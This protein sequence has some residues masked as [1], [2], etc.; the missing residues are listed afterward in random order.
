MS[1][2]FVL[3]SCYSFHVLAD[4]EIDDLRPRLDNEWVQIQEDK[5]NDIRAYIRHED[6]KPFRSFKADMRLDVSIKTL[7]SVILNFDNYTKWYWKTQTS[8]ILKEHSP[9]HFIIYVVHDAPYNI[10][11]L[12]VILDAVVKPQS[13]SQASI[14]LKVSALPDY[15]AVKPHLKRMLAEDMSVKITPLPNDRVHV[16][17]HGYFEVRNHILP[18]WAANI[19]QRTAPYTVLT[20]LKKIAHLTHHQKSST[21][22]GFAV[23]NH[24]EYQAK[25]NPTRP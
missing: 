3:A 21:P 20:Q 18:K 8:K 5:R 2:W 19:I 6:D 9:T 11:D 22:V 23:Y 10:P 4:S 14:T 13:T 24:E 15:L 16:E 17:V 12:D 25:F 7:I 1:L